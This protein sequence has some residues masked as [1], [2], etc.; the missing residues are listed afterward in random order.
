M[1]IVPPR[2]YCIIANPVIRQNVEIDYS[3]LRKKLSLPPIITSLLRTGKEEDKSSDDILDII[4]S[5]ESNKSQVE[6][7]RFGSEYF[8]L[9]L[10]IQVKPNSDMQIVKCD[11][12]KMSHSHSTPVNSSLDP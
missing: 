10:T 4:K 1:I 11:L 5:L 2:H 3:S 6:L 12:N 9:H 8:H 7:D